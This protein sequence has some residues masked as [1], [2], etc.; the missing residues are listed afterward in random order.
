M[1]GPLVDSG[2]V[3]KQR[4]VVIAPW[5]EWLHDNPQ[6][7]VLSLNTGHRRNYGSGV[8]YQDYFASAD[9]MFPT[10][11]DQ[12]LLKQKDYVFGVRQFGAAKAWPLTAF[13]GGQVIND[14]MGG[15][16]LVLIGDLDGRT[17]RAFE[18]RDHEFTGETDGI[19]DVAGAVW[20]ASE[21]ALTSPTGETLPRVAGHI[22]Y[23][24]AWSGY[25][26]E[27]AELYQP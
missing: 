24:F 10:Q 6:T 23:W 25:L 4:P 11:V 7:Q 19:T 17:V 8:V 27:T 22:A 5:Q 16:N 14:T 18:R 12:D 2:M 15:R 26:G 20:S 9:L 3:L 21:E 1:A 13:K